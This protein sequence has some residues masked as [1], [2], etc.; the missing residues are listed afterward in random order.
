LA[1]VSIIGIAW[2]AFLYVFSVAVSS[3]FLGAPLMFGSVRFTGGAENPHQ[4]AIFLMLAASSCIRLAVRNQAKG[5]KSWYVALALVAVLIAV[6][7][8]SDTYTAALSAGAFVLLLFL[9]SRIVGNPVTR[10]ALVFLGL[11]SLLLFLLFSQSR[12]TAV[13]ANWLEGSTG[14]EGRL[15]L[16]QSFIYSLERSPLFGLG[17]GSHAEVAGIGLLE[18]HNSYLDIAAM[19]GFAGLAV[20]LIFLAYILRQMIRSDPSL[21]IIAVPLLVYATAGFAVRRTLF[22]GFMTLLLLAARGLAEQR[23]TRAES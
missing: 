2:Y 5:K 15:F 10:V 19:A 17:P 16:W 11:S 1:R 22:W 4:L 23:N 21:L 8:R 13:V 9:L 14:G 20:F 6:Q 7:T 18:F 3:T 12:V